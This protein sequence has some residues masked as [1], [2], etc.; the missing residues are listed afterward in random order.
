MI[1][2]KK[3]IK[4]KSTIKTTPT[5]KSLGEGKVIVPKKQIYGRTYIAGRGPRITEKDKGLQVGGEKVRTLKTGIV[6]RGLKSKPIS[7]DEIDPGAIITFNY[8]GTTAHDPKPIILYLGEFK[9]KVHGLN[10]KYVPKHLLKNLQEFVIKERIE[11]EAPKLF[12]ET[13]LKKFIKNILVNKGIASY[14]TYLKS[15]I[16]SPR[17]Y[18]VSIGEIEY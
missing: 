4:T 8:R 12:Y 16:S 7:I 17:I 3:T 18:T 14:R 2:T 13:K 15:G 6:G 11:D 10:M 5:K 9:K 1:K